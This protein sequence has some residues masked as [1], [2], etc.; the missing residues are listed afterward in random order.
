MA[1]WTKLF[2]SMAQAQLK[3]RVEDRK[4][5]NYLATVERDRNAASMSHYKDLHVERE[6]AAKCKREADNLAR[7]D[8][9]KK[10]RKT[11]TGVKQITL[12]SAGRSHGD[13]GDSATTDAE[14]QKLEKVRR[15]LSEQTRQARGMGR[16][17]HRIRRRVAKMNLHN[18][19]PLSLP[20]I[21]EG[22]TTFV[23]EGNLAVPGD[24]QS[25]KTAFPADNAAVSS[26]DETRLPLIGASDTTAGH[27]REVRL[28]YSHRRSFSKISS[29]LLSPI[30]EIKVSEERTRATVNLPPSHRDSPTPTQ[31]ETTDTGLGEEVANSGHATATSLPPINLANR[32]TGDVGLKDDTSLPE[33]TTTMQSFGSTIVS[34]TVETMRAVDIPV[35]TRTAS[36]DFNLPPLV[37]PGYRKFALSDTRAHRRPEAR[38]QPKRSSWAD[39]WIG[40]PNAIGSVRRARVAPEQL[41]QLSWAKSV[42]FK[43]ILMADEERFQASRRQLPKVAVSLPQL[44]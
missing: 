2:R 44:R 28:Q 17:V 4:L 38:L 16:R 18:Q 24:Q 25:E 6:F 9:L 42:K 20:T 10:R 34:V 21:P 14:L 7:R 31:S 23:T 33:T 5:A 11:K 12:R 30:D 41:S 40:D 13:I 15:R 1:N 8:G 22:R 29:L 32:A 36:R 37:I 39:F 35:Y 26:G 19:P 43:R 27:K 3:N